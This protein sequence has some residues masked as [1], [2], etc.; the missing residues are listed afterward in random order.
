[1]YH[2]TLNYGVSGNKLE[3]VIFQEQY[4]GRYYAKASN[5]RIQLTRSYNEALEKYDVLVMPTIPF[6]AP[7][8]PSDN[9]SLLG[10]IYNKNKYNKMKF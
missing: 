8:L 3:N 5:L 2:Q 9:D 10:R 4:H 6:T 7:A 1:M